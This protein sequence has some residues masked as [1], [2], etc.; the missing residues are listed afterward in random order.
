[1]GTEAHKVDGDAGTQ[2]GRGPWRMV[3]AMTDPN[4]LKSGLLQPW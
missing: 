1:M 2:R 4:M 3:G